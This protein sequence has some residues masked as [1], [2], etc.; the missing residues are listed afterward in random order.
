MPS[1][2]PKQKDVLILIVKLDKKK[3]AKYIVEKHVKSFTSTYEN[4]IINK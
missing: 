1:Y 4:Y 3:T 2:N